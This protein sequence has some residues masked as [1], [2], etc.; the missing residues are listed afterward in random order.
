MVK[1]RNSGLLTGSKRSYNKKLLFRVKYNSCFLVNIDTIRTFSL[2]HPVLWRLLLEWLL[3]WWGQ[4]SWKKRE[5]GV[6]IH[7]LQHWTVWQLFQ[8]RRSHY[9]WYKHSF[10]PEGFGVSIQLSSSKASWD[11]NCLPRPKLQHSV[12]LLS[13]C[14]CSGE[15][16]SVSSCNF[17]VCFNKKS[18]PDYHSFAACWEEKA[19]FS[20]WP[21]FWEMLK[22]RVKQPC[23]AR[24]GRA[25]YTK[26]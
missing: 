23:G 21:L 17:P 2:G 6:I 11:S 18:R 26:L 20:S 4:I 8:H 15:K 1:L 19:S 16:A 13:I 12:G 24:L 22:H 7:Y 10:Q 5:N 25:A 14:S 3:S 9:H